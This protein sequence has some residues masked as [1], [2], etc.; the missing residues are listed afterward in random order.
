MNYS[1]SDI[2]KNT[3]QIA[4]MSEQ[5]ISEN[6]QNTTA[7]GADFT[8]RVYEK[9]TKKHPDSQLKKIAA[10][11][12]A[13]GFRQP[14]VVERSGTLIV[15]HGRYLA[16]TKVLGWSE[17]REA[18]FAKKGEQFIPYQV[19]DDLTP[20]EIKAYRLADNKLNESAWEMEIVVEEL[21]VL[22]AGLIQLTGFNPSLVFEQ[23]AES[24][25]VPEL[26]KEAQTKRGDIYVLG[27]HRLMCGDSTDESD[28]A[29]LM[30]N[31]VASMVFTDPP[32]AIYGSSTGVNASVAD[33]K[34][35]R[36]FFK[37]ILQ[38]CRKFSR[39]YGHVYICC[40]WRSW[41]S[42]W[43]INKEI[44]LQVKNMIVWDKKSPGM[45][46]MYTNQ[47]ELLFFAVN[48]TRNTAFMTK[49]ETGQ[50]RV[51]GVANIWK[52]GREKQ[53]K[54]NAQKPVE[55]IIKAIK[56]STDEGGLVLDVFGGSGST[57]IAAE[58]IKRR[59]FMMEIDPVF[60][61]VI[62]QRFCDFSKSNVIIKNGKELKWQPSK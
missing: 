53:G 15:G 1:E 41:A 46:S 42:W 39:D 5:P 35:V 33:D 57:L 9:N 62:V 29:L 6:S 55:L 52:I 20:D 17:L 60:C 48:H 24:D 4:K 43:E 22:P 51:T 13:F 14:C 8:I 16:A 54:H 37:S 18:P 49:K 45:G 26:P 40:D 36:P 47:H 12:Q 3:H 30:D 2:L 23:S 56:N 10:S 50:R 58:Q 25:L 28:L 34:M 61:D 21:K 7:P 19:A 27:Q 31:Q 32:Y 38:M 59:C 11:I 44:G